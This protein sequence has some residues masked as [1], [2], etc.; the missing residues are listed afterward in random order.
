MFID[1]VSLF[2]E[3]LDGFLSTS[4]IARAQKKGLVHIQTHS[5]RKWAKGKHAITDDRPFGGGAGMLLKPEP[6]FE[7]VENLRQ[8]HHHSYIIYPSPE[9]NKFSTPKAK[10]LSQ[11]EHLIFLSGHYE[12]IDE[13]VREHLVDEEISIGD[14]VITNGTLAATVVMDALIRYI[15]GVL[16]DEES[17]QQDSFTDNL[18][19]FPQYT[20]PEIF[21]GWPAP[22]ILL[23]GNHQAI[24]QWRSQQRMLRT[25]E[26]RQDIWSTW[27]KHNK[28]D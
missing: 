11:K 14:Y 24:Q 18:L 27:Q 17:L 21:R 3:M 4:M 10:E 16:G 6:L 13:R 26:R 1:V 9:G 5:L 15:P 12:G 23:S 2:P 22:P 7:A 19:S 20:R 28:K 8:N 25:R